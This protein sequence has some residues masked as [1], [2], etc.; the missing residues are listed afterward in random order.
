MWEQVAR[1]ILV[2]FNRS[3]S[4]YR[5]IDRNGTESA[6]VSIPLAGNLVQARDVQHVLDECEFANNAV[7]NLRESRVE[8]QL[9]RS[10]KADPD[11]TDAL[12][13]RFSLTPGLLSG[14]DL[15]TATRVA[16]TMIRASTTSVVPRIDM[17]FSSS[18]ECIVY[19]CN[20]NCIFDHNCLCFDLDVALL[21]YLFNT[22]EIAYTMEL[23]TTHVSKRKKKS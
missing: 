21:S 6:V 2:K 11:Y 7:V 12:D 19:A 10:Q 20:R 23:E 15:E 14:Q 1:D 4:I 13:T 8:F 9:N 18:N 5:I 22:G 17:E 16:Q 3:G